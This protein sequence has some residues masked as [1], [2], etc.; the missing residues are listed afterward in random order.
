MLILAKLPRRWLL[1]ALKHHNADEDGAS[2]GKGVAE[3]LLA[4]SGCPKHPNFQEGH[5]LEARKRRAVRLSPT[6]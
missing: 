2:G 4:A 1:R 3:R 6:R 5:R